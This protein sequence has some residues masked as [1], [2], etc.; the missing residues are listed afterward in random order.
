[1]KNIYLGAKPTKLELVYVKIQIMEMFI[2]FLLGLI[3]RGDRSFSE[4]SMGVDKIK[5]MLA[6]MQNNIH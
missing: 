1:M 6:Q 2:G 3:I 5:D 4:P